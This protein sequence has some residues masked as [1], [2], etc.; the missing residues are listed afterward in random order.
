MDCIDCHNRVGH[1]VASPDQA[2]DEAMS[3][4]KISPDLPYIKRNSVALLNGSYASLDAADK[5]ITGL[6]DTYAAKYPL[7]LKSHDAQ[8]SGAIDEL[9]AVY[10][11]IATPAMKVQAK[12]YPDNLGHQNS[13]GCFRCHDGAHYLVVKGKIT[14]E[15]I[16]SE[17]STC[18]TF[19]QIGTGATDAS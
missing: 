8:V 4:G 12:T 6:R 9:K 15:K 5:A 7:V 3:A 11:L 19:P 14:N 13:P 17:C 10:R 16:P 2:V 1:A 18:H